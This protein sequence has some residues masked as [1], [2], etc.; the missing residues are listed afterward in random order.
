MLANT[1]IG[2]WALVAAAVLGPTVAVLLA[3][4]HRQRLVGRLSNLEDV[5]RRLRT[6][7]PNS[8]FDEREE[9]SLALSRERLVLTNLLDRF[10]EVTQKFVNVETLEALG[11]CVLSA[12]ERVLDCEYG[13]AFV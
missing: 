12:F 4:R 1:D 6:A 11:A 5:L 13:V 9:T 7:D 3:L 10:P 2:I 8:P